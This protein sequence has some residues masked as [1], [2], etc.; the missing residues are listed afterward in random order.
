MAAGVKGAFSSLRAIFLAERCV[1]T[2]ATMQV[3]RIRMMV[4]FRIYS[5]SIP[6]LYPTMMMARVAA[7]WELLSP[8][9][10]VLCVVV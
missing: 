4:P 3:S 7:A 10:S 5:S 2:D 9:I 6:A 1:K 8:N